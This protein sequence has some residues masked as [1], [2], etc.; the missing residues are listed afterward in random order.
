MAEAPEVEVLAQDLRD[1]V[2]GRPITAVAVL[3]PAAVR[4]PAPGDYAALLTGRTSAPAL[5]VTP[6]G[7]KGW[8]LRST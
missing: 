8:R 3:E 4:F 6:P 2:A 5:P 7:S 1:C